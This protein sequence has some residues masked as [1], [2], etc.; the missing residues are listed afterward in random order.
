M[1]QNPVS[2]KWSLVENAIDYLHSSAYFYFK[3][4]QKGYE[5]KGYKSIGE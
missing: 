2:G 1:H 5:V 3:G 4:K